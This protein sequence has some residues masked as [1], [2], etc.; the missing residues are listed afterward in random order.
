MK[1][2]VGKGRLLC[3]PAEVFTESEGGISFAISA[4]DS[5]KAMYATVIQSQHDGFKKGDV[6]Y[7]GKFSGI[8]VEVEKK[9]YLVIAA[10]EVLLKLDAPKK[11]VVKKTKGV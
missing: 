3:K 8:E 6:V 11:A 1:I 9:T 7:F 2:T 5:M 10:D 4:L